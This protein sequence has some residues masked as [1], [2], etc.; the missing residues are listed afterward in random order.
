M[1]YPTLGI[2]ANALYIG[3]NNFCGSPTQTFNSTDGYVVRKSSILSAGPLVVTAFRGLV[4]TSTGAGPFT[5][6]GVDNYDSASNEGYFIGVDN[7][8]FG[9]LMLRRVSTP[10]ATPTI[11]A[12]ISIGVNTTEFPIT[13][14]HLGNTGSTNGNLDGLDDRLF[15][16]HI[17]NGRLRRLRARAAQ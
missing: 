17:R 6:R 11:S 5:P 12:N 15:A 10:G 3:G 2:D 13:V 4:A 8:S 9:T 1:D 14:P 7:A 16:A